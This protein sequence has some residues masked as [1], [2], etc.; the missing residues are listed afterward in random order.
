[1]ITCDIHPQLGASNICLWDVHLV[2]NL[3]FALWVLSFGEADYESSSKCISK[4]LACGWLWCYQISSTAGFEETMQISLWDNSLWC[5]CLIFRHSYCNGLRSAGAR[6]RQ[7]VM[8]M[9]LRPIAIL[10]L[11]FVVLMMCF[12]P[13]QTFSVDYYWLELIL[14]YIRRLLPWKMDV[15][16]FF[17]L[18]YLSKIYF[19]V[20]NFVKHLSPVYTAASSEAA[21]SGAL[22]CGFIFECLSNLTQ[23]EV[24][25]ISDHVFAA[26]ALLFKYDQEFLLKRRSI[27]WSGTSFENMEIPTNVRQ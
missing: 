18:C 24:F 12:H 9:P 13:C 11:G 3:P 19:S 26:W 22:N 1:M 8:P 4:L 7:H 17:F 20:S 27:T 25:A 5:S 2:E 14:S 21:G 16:S 10:I 15:L 23:V 6:L